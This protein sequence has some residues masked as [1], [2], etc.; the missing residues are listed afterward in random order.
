MTGSTFRLFDVLTMIA[1]ALVLL[2][3]TIAARQL[4]QSKQDITHCADNLRKLYVAHG[5][6]VTAHGK[7]PRTRFEPDKP[8]T[9]FTGSA[10]TNPFAADGPQANDV[11][12]AIFLLAR[13][14]GISADVFNCPAALRNGLAEQDTFDAT[15]VRQRS[16]FRA[17]VNYNYSFQ[18]M[19]LPA[20][21]AGPSDVMA[22]DTNPGGQGILTATTQETL[23]QVRLSN[24]PNHQRDGQN[25]LFRNGEVRFEPSAFFGK[26]VDNI[27][28]PGGVELVPE[29][30]AGPDVT[31]KAVSLRRWAFSIAMVATTLLLIF[32]VFRGRRKSAGLRV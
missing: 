21:S 1:I 29:W 24:S 11:T 23:Q 15:T 8:I 5:A 9:A 27:Y 22:A 19:Y 6:Y 7:P 10:S 26:P 13:E 28:A 2:S 18:N 14:S 4:A 16:N 25:V 17:R 30:S 3:A 32:I 12:A 31:P 20:D